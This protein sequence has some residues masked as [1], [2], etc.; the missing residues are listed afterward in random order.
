MVK[1]L[2]VGVLCIIIKIKCCV[3]SSCLLPRHRLHL[4]LKKVTLKEFDNEATMACIR[5]RNGNPN[6]GSGMQGDQSK[7]TNI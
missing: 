6:P 4:L 3:D 5:I 2:G 7:F 1:M